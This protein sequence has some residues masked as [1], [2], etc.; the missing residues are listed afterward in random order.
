MY[1]QFKTLLNNKKIF[2]TK[3]S[4]S[5]FNERNKD[6][7]SLLEKTILVNKLCDINRF[8]TKNNIHT[9]V[10]YD[11]KKYNEMMY[12][13]H[14]KYH[15]LY[16]YPFHKNTCSDN[17]SIHEYF[18]LKMRDGINELYTKIFCKSVTPIIQ[19]GNGPIMLKADDL[20]GC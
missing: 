11:F 6:A 3:F 14:R 10:Y 2:N 4:F 16:F 5:N 19:Y 9:D 17:R 7:F 8:V 18:F 12:N 15:G 1:R 20:T 13:R